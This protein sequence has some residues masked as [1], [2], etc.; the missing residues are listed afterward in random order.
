MLMVDC[1]R[2]ILRGLDSVKRGVFGKGLDS[3]MFY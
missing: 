1:W 2:I 3:N